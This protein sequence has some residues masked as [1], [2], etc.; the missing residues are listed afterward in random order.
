MT[1]NTTILSER[2]S[3]LIENLIAKYGLIVNFD[4]VLR[5][6]SGEYS[7]Q[8]ARNL[9]SKM[10]RNGWLVRIKKGIYYIASLESRGFIGVSVFVIAGILLEESYVSFESALQYYGIFDQHIKIVSSVCLKKYTGK[11]IQG[12]TYKFIKTSKK[13]FCGWQETRIEGQTVKVAILEKAILD[14]IRSK[15]SIY[16]LDLVLEKLKKYK[17]SFNFEKLWDLAQKQS[18]TVQKILGFLLDKAEINSDSIYKLLENN[19]GASFMTKDSRLFSAKWNLYY[20]N[21]FA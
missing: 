13:N 12:I 5:E 19:K 6:L 10:S 4:Q 8:Q 11:T 18:I 14:M 2:E 15:R 3:S 17:N 1:Q 21:Y 9:V 7:R 20:H 16:S